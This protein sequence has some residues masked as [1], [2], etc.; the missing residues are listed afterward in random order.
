MSVQPRHSC[1]IQ[2]ALAAALGGCAAHNY[3]NW[4]ESRTRN[5]T[6]YTDAKVE[7]EFIQEWLERSY[8]AYQA[9][10][11]DLKPGNVNVVW[12]KNEPGVWTRVFSPFDDPRAGWT[13]ETVPSGNRIGRDGLIVLERRDEYSP[14]GSTF[15]MQS[16]RDENIAKEQ[17][18]HLFIMRQVPMAPLWLQVGLGRYMSKY[19]VHYKGE[20]FMACFGSPVFDEP[21]RMTAEGRAQGGG[22][23]VSIP[24]DELLNSD[25]YK[26]DRSLRYWYEFTA[27]AFV[28]YLIHGENGYNGTRFSLLLKAFRDGKDT[29][30]ALALAYPHI[31]PD[32]WDDKLLR[33][34]RPT[35]RR[36]LTS[37]D[38]NL[39]H[40]LCFRVPT[41]HD[42]DFKPTRR[43]A[44]PQEIQVLL[45]DLDRV[46][47]FRRHVTWFPTDIVEAE[48]AK[49]P[50][51]GGAQPGKGEEK[52]K[53]PKE[54]NGKIP[55]VRTPGPVP[56][57]P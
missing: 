11:P 27:Y 14:S 55:T 30:E 33:H 10:F 1:V 48:A 12:L 2:I 51:K 17:M 25:W 22:R 20:S 56:A 35:N 57:G 26:Y 18:A 3:Q 13:L 29:E 53:A 5:V 32:E 39:V 9:F 42:A 45:E 7:H 4:A 16:I 21:I 28:H 38:P 15:R 46:E 54:D 37:T 24:V 19:R 41:E 6:V 34:M 8:T 47:P 43:P 23:R 31:L 40:G 44:N 50:R 49:R 36:A 52:D